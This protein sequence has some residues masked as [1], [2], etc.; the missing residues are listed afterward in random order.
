[1]TNS[2]FP[3]WADMFIRKW[4]AAI[5]NCFVFHF[6]TRD[7]VPGQDGYYLL[8]DYLKNLL[9]QREMIILYDISGGIQFLKGNEEEFKKLIG[10]KNQPQSPLASIAGTAPQGLPR[11]ASS[12]LPLLEKAL[13]GNK[14]KSKVALIID[15]AEMIFP[16]ESGSVS[17][18]EDRTNIV[19]LQR[20]AND[21][22]IGEA[23]S[24]IILLTSNLVDIHSA[25]RASD[26]GIEEIIIKKPDIE[27]RQRYI[28]YKAKD[29]KDE[30]AGISPRQLAYITAGLSRIQIED[31]FL[32][33]RE[34]W[35]ILSQKLVKERKYEILEK[36]HKDE[37][38]RF[39]DPIYGWETVGGLWPIREKLMKVLRAMEAGDWRRVPMGILFTGPP[40]TGK[41]HVA[42]VIAKELGFNFVEL[43]NIKTKW[44]GESER[45][46]AKVLLSVK[47]NTPIVWFI[48]E[49]DQMLGRRD[50]VS[51]DSGVNRALFGEFLKF[52]S[53]PTN[54]GKVL[55]IGATNRSDLMDP[56]MK[57]P[58]RFDLRIPFL[59]PTLEERADIFAAMMRKYQYR[60]FISDFTSFAKGPFY[61]IL[62]KEVEINGSDIE[63]M[64]RYAYDN[65]I[66]AGKE[67]I[68]EENLWQGIGEHIPC[69][70][71]EF[72]YMT[73]VAIKECSS[74]SL[75]KACNFN[76]ILKKLQR[77][78][79]QS[80]SKTA[81]SSRRVKDF[82][83]AR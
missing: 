68:K 15:Y 64:V 11:T 43:G 60:C 62:G 46:L 66:E 71:K 12:A 14:E 54:R 5:A 81:P 35:G 34:S 67:E 7:Y 27:E 24:I 52:M 37:G 76:E 51:T 21:P 19:T 82:P 2:S 57:R 72:D 79:E 3:V 49:I 74:R 4:R 38:L 40:G 22:R 42:Q 20:W 50:E 10:F 33:A 47:A 73:W 61:D 83:V 39:V 9:S 78:S 8:S 18:A 28:E 80:E 29:Y 45:I 16:A 30:M 36:Q 65:A 55:V 25:L 6:N 31:I 13:A 56:A 77:Q 59:F 23:D 70:D 26:S 1:M 69:Y 48:D 63:V 41:S 44:V 53:D 17:S 75:L 58:G 32:R